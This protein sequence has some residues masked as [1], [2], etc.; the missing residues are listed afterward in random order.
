MLKI[1]N[2]SATLRV[3]FSEPLH[4][5]IFIKKIILANIPPMYAAEV[6]DY[7]DLRI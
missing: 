4:K 6:G 7:M 1:K 3:N 2:Y 5:R